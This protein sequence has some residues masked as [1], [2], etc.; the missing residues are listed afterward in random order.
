[1]SRPRRSTKTIR[2]WS[3]AG[4][5]R[6]VIESLGLQSGSE[7]IQFVQNAFGE[8][9]RVTADVR[10]LEASEDDDKGG[11]NDDL[12]RGR[13]I[14]RTLSDDKIV[15]AIAIR[16]GAWLTRVLPKIDFDTLKTRTRPIAILG[17]SEITG[18]LN[19]TAG[20]RK[21]IAIHDLCPSF[22]RATKK[23][24]SEKQL[25]DQFT[26][27]FSDVERMIT[28]QPS[29]R[30]IQAR[31]IQ[32]QFSNPKNISIVG[33]NL[34]LLTTLI[35]TPYAK[36]IA[37][38]KHCWLLLEDVHEPPWRI[39]RMLAHFTLAGWLQR[40]DGFI[41]GRFTN[42]G[43]DI[44]NA[45]RICLEKQLAP[46]ISPIILA[47]NIGHVL[48]MAPIPLGKRVVTLTV[49]NDRN[50]RFDIAWPK[51]CVTCRPHGL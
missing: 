48:P 38:R 18:L 26:N 45:V 42:H 43:E 51:P 21:T 37:P 13:E 1:M 31:L 28:G 47:N 32:G 25:R 27:F 36:S 4:S 50:V 40:Y 16:G 17:F 35:G 2:L 22:L 30:T 44:T 14:E 33:G 12:R 34:S 8:N 41:L 24:P 39:D 19:I 10:T 29:H 20:Y 5:C 15:A 3:I 6:P 23:R 9:Y 46:A 11:R 49:G 7:L